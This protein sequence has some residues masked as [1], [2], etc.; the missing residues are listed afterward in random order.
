[1]DNKIL[2]GIISSE[3]IPINKKQYAERII[4]L[5][6]ENKAQR[7]KLEVYEKLLNTKIKKTKQHHKETDKSYICD[8]PLE[9]RRDTET[10]L[11]RKNAFAYMKSPEKNENLIIPIVNYFINNKKYENITEVN[12]KDFIKNG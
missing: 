7:K 1:M 6:A 8:E 10:L 2:D 12:V 3:Y 5:E 9:L 11:F 4:K